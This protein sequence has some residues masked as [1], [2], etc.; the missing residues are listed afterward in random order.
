MNPSQV[1]LIQ[2]TNDQENAL[3]QLLQYLDQ[4]KLDHRIGYNYFTGGWVKG[5]LTELKDVMLGIKPMD[6]Q[7]GQT[8]KPQEV[9]N[10]TT[11]G[12]IPLSFTGR[13]LMQNLREAVSELLTKAI[14]EAKKGERLNFRHINWEEVSKARGRIAQYMSKL[15]RGVLSETSLDEVLCKHYTGGKLTDPVIPNTSIQ[16]NNFEIQSGYD[17]VKWA[18]GLIRQLPETHDGR[19]SW[20]LNFGQPK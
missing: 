6:N 14:D 9:Y 18:E 10:S 17:R 16:L 5:Q 19:N 11:L 20:L 15:E 8:G 12:R 3:V 13:R 7:T 2:I 4:L 1:K